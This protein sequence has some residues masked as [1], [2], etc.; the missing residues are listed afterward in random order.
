MTQE[1][2]TRLFGAM[3]NIKKTHL[4]PEYWSPSSDGEISYE[5]RKWF[6]NNEPTTLTHYLYWCGNNSFS[7]TRTAIGG[8]NYILDIQN[9]Y[10]YLTEHFEE[11]G[12][13]ECPDCN[14]TG[15]W[16]RGGDKEFCVSCDGSGRIC[17]YPEA[18]KILKGER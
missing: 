14:G 3:M 2:I 10:R 15:L 9:F 13:T 1:F 17:K 12:Y 5:V 18:E 16:Y 8:L 7:R 11:W 6:E 4:V